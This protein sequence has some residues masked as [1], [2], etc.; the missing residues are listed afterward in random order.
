MKKK[1]RM[2]KISIPSNVTRIV[3]VGQFSERIADMIGFSDEERDNLAIAVTEAVNN[4]IIHGNKYNESKKVIVTYHLLDNGVKVSVR[5]EGGGFN[6]GN[7]KNPVLP[8][9]LM[10]EHGRGIFIVKTLMDKVEFNFNRKGTEL[11]ITKYKNTT[12]LNNS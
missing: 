10:K 4:A 6:P 12:N 5:D 7:V 9:N 8:D 2:Y 11:I 3:E 1:E